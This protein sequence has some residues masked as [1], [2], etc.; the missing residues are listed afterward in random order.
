MI[1]EEI[2]Y[3][4]IYMTHNIYKDEEIEYTHTHDS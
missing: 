4:I 3:N 1:D 2:E